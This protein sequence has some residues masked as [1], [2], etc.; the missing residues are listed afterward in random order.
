MNT[1]TMS[2]YLFGGHEIT[3]KFGLVQQEIL[4]ILPVYNMFCPMSAGNGSSPYVSHKR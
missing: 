4:V 1:I 3:T 2:I